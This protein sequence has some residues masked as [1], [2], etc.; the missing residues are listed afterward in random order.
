MILHCPLAY[1]KICGDVLA[2]MPREHEIQDLPLTRRQAI[3]MRGGGHASFW[4][5][6]GLRVLLK[7]MRDAGDQ[8]FMTER[9]F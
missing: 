4:R 3:E 5:R 9:F 1:A 8:V 7:R 6:P 2:G